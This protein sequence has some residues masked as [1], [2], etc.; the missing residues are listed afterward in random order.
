MIL[1]S[2]NLIYSENVMLKMI[3]TNKN[4]E[5]MIESK[6]HRRV[7]SSGNT[8][9]T[10]SQAFIQACKK[11]PDY[12]CTCCHRLMYRQTVVEFNSAK[13]EK[14]PTTIMDAIC[15]PDLMHY[16][17]QHKNVDMQNL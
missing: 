6:E 17:F 5:S 7:S 12:V 3:K 16:Q 1:L 15:H 8:M 11:G 14:L 4:R 10:A 2:A 13:Y 9:N